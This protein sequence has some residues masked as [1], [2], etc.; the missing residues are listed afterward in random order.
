MP[1][2]ADGRRLGGVG[3]GSARSWW[4]YLSGSILVPVVGITAD[5][6]RQIEANEATDQPG[7]T[8]SL[9]AYNH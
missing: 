1:R 9:T 2:H 4:T 3:V 7:P 6:A 8:R 5:E